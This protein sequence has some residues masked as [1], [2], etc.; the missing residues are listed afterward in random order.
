MNYLGEENVRYSGQIPYLGIDEIA[1]KAEELLN[2]CWDGC[3]PI[4]IEVICDYLGIA[5]VPVRGLSEEIGAEAYLAV[6]FKTIYV[7]LVGYKKESA[8]Y[9]F[10]V[11]HELGHYVLHQVYYP[12]E[13]GS[14]E[15]W[16]CLVSNLNYVE[17]QANYFAGSLLAPEEELIAALNAEFEGS[18]VRNC[19]SKEHKEF[20]DA[21]SKLRKSFKISKQ[22]LSRRMR[23]LMPGAEKFDE[24]AIELRR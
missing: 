8:R 20:S 22:V 3:F 5:V 19:W 14:L 15:E 4:N 21:L 13:L 6:D 7:D 23:D 10:S 1:Q 16:Q 11:A 9:R 18:F 17:F 24:V 12:C 2:E